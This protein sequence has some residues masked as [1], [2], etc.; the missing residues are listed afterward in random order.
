[1]DVDIVDAI[2]GGVV[3]VAIEMLSLSRALS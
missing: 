1:V 3:V 2:G